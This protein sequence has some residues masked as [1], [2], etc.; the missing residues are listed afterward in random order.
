METDQTSRRS[1]ICVR[2]HS[3]EECRWWAASRTGQTG[4][5]ELN[6]VQPHVSGNGIHGWHPSIQVRRQTVTLPEEAGSVDIDD[7]VL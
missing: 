4:E 5:A 7:P 1:N 6:R 3:R 2:I